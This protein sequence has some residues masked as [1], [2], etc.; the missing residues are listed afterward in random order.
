VSLWKLV[1]KDRFRKLKDFPLTIPSTFGNIYSTYV[2][3]S[4]FSTT[5]QVKFKNRNSMAEETLDDRP[6]RATTKTGRPID[7]RIIVSE[8]K[9]LDKRHP[10]YRDL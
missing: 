7:K 2:C 3:E 9:S 8:L 4:T 5:K 6:R 1:S 10:T